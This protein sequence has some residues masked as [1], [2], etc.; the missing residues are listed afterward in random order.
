[1]AEEEKV[2]PRGPDAGPED[3]AVVE[4]EDRSVG[5]LVLDISERLTLL[6][7]DEIAL[8]K[9]EV[10]EKVGKLVRGSAAAGLA[11][12]FL[13]LAFAML[14]HTFAWLLNDLFFEG[15]LWLGF[16]FS[17]LIWLVLAS[18]A[19]LFAYRAMRAGAPPTPDM[20]IEEVKRT[21]ETLGGG[22]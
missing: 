1:M 4:D 10:S 21:G 7:R 19:G 9:A 18:L 22:E 15:E 14:M 8:A 6:V 2:D 16:F 20:A 12:L 17:A 13:V 11:A 3:E 5:E